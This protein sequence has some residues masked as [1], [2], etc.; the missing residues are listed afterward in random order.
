MTDD[1]KRSLFVEIWFDLHLNVIKTTEPDKPLESTDCE[2]VT[3]PGRGSAPGWVVVVGAGG[4]EELRARR[5]AMRY[6]LTRTRPAL[7]AARDYFHARD[8][9]AAAENLEQLN[10]PSS[11]LS[12]EVRNAAEFLDECDEFSRAMAW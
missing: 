2:S 4:G 3:P 5:A 7:S 10:R 8:L 11:A 1:T 9:V 12:G 6:L